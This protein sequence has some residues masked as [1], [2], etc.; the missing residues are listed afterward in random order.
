[1]SVVLVAALVVFLMAMFVLAGFAV[2][3]VASALLYGLELIPWYVGIPLGVISVV[4]L[5]CASIV[6]R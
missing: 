2:I 6:Y 4:I 3:G 5:G 1:M